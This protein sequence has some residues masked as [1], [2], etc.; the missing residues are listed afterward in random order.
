GWIDLARPRLSVVPAAEWR[1]MYREAWRLQRDNFWTPTL[2]D[3]DWQEVYERYL[4]VLE[5][6]AT[7]GEF[8]DLMWEVQGELGTS[9]AYEWGG[10]VRRPPPHGPGYLGADLRR[11]GEAWVIARLVRGASWGAE[12]PS[13]LL[14]PG[15]DV[16]DGDRLLAIDGVPLGAAREPGE[17]L[18]NR[19]GTDV[20][21]TVARGDAAPRA[22]TV[23][24]LRDERGARYRDWVERT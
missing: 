24:T 3:I 13:P 21:L 23:T 20:T 19:A 10:D 9:H 2:S 5:R 18:V 8:S 4:P 12:D 11:E 6:V 22:V 15:L 17:L 7:R 1:Q 16:Q 14:A